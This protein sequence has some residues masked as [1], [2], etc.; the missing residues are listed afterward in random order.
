MDSFSQNPSTFCRTKRNLSNHQRLAIYETLLMES[1]AGKLKRGVVKKVATLFS[2]DKKTV[3][4]I[5]QRGK[6]CVAK[7]L[8]VDVSAKCARTG[9]RKRVHINFA[10]IANIDL[11]DRTN[12]RSLAEALKVP[13]STLHR[14]IKEGAIRPHSNALKPYL[15]EENKRARLQF[16][17]SMLEPN[18][19]GSQPTFKQMYDRVHIDEK[20]FYLSRES[21]RYYLLPEEEEPLRTCK[22]KRFITKVMFLAAVARPRFDANHN[23]IFSGKIGIFPFTCKVPAKRNSKNRA[24]GTMETKAM[25]VTKDVIRSCLIEKILPAIRSKWPQ[26]SAANPIYIQ[27]DNARPH[28]HPLDAEFVEAAHKDGFNIQLVCQPPNSPDMNVLDLGFFRAIQSL[29]HQQA[30]KNIDELVFAVQKS[31]EQLESQNLDNVFLTLQACMIE[32]MK[33]NGANNY[34][35]PHLGKGQLMR[36]G[37]LPS[38]LHCERGLLQ[39]VL[40][41]L[42]Q[43]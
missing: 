3:R 7:G 34:K 19:L 4:R 37:T 35:L 1:V 17:V 42:Q 22:S 25:T 43:Q 11:R 32:V 13:R 36:E 41:H 6:D 10:E 8:T 30:P 14:R 21:E 39:N 23:E 16:C 38:Q 26:S 29:Q 5:W 12:I 27:Q 31:F 18:S 9:G 28:I 24:A 40:A 15:S 33:V 2:V 20:W